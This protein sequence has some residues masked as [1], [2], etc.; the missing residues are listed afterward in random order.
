MSRH[1]SDT[2]FRVKNILS[3]MLYSSRDICLQ[4]EL[5]VSTVPL[6][7]T[8]Q[9]KFPTK[10]FFHPLYTGNAIFYINIHKVLRTMEQDTSL[11]S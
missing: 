10:C 3:Q 1:F 9:S 8:L 2:H 7:V 4:V 6:Q 5:K 11:I